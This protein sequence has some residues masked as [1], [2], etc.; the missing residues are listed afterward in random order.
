MLKGVLEAEVEVELLAIPARGAF[1]PL[2]RLA[3]TPTAAPIVREHGVR[4][5]ATDDAAR[6]VDLALMASNQSKRVGAFVPND[7][8]ELAM[9]AL[10]RAIASPLAADGAMAVVFEDDPVACPASCPRQAAMRLNIPCLEPANLSQLRDV[11]EFAMRLS[12]AGSSPVAIVVHHDLL[13]SSDTLRMRPNRVVSRFD[14]PLHHRRRRRAPRWGEAGGVMRIARRLELNAG[15]SIPSPGERVPVGFVTVGPADMALDHVIHVMKLIGRVP[16]LSLALV[17]P[18]DEVALERLLGR[19][20]HVV[21][22]EPRP[23]SVEAEV[24]A[25]AESLRCRGELTASVW[26]RELPPASDRETHCMEPGDALHPSTLARRV[27]HLLHQIRPTLDVASHLLRNVPA[28]NAGALPARGAGLGFAAAQQRVRAILAEAAPRLSDAA[29]LE[30]L[31][32]EP[33]SLLL[34]G[35]ERFGDSKRTVALEIWDGG[36]LRDEGLAAIRQAARDEQPRIVMILL[37]GDEPLVDVERL[38]AAAIPSDQAARCRVRT[39]RLGEPEELRDVIVES[40]IGEGFTAIVVDDA[41]SARF[42]PL[43]IERGLREVDRLGFSPVQT[44]S[45]PAEHVCDLRPLDSFASQLKSEQRELQLREKRVHVETTRPEDRTGGV[46]RIVPLL[47]HVEVVRSK[48]PMIAPRLLAATR[49]TAP[50]PVHAR[51]AQWRCHVAGWRGAAPGVATRV[52]ASAGRRMGYHVRVIHDPSPCSAGWRAFSQVLFTR[53]IDDDSALPLTATIPYGE[54]DLLVGVDPAES[55]R[56]LAGDRH[57]LV[58][59]PELTYAVVNT[60][61]LSGGP[62]GESRGVAEQLEAALEQLTRSERRVVLD[63][64]SMGRTV[65]HTDRVIDLMLLGAAFQHGL[66]PVAIEAME[67]ALR[68]VETQGIGRALE[69]FR[70]GRVLATERSLLDKPDERQPEPVRKVIR[71]MALTLRRSK[72]GGAQSARRFARLMERLLNAT[73]GLAETEAGREARRDAVSAVYQCFF[74]GGMP[75]AEQYVDRLIRVYDADRGDHG[76]ML[77]RLVVLPLAEA[78]LIR[79]HLHIAAMA[80]AIEHRRQIRERMNVKRTRGD[81]FER[82]YVTRIELQ[83]FG[84]RVTA[85]VRT[86]D[87]PARIMSRAS[88]WIPISF[89]GTA[90]QRALRQAM[91]DLVDKIVEAAEHDYDRYAEILRNLH[92]HAVNKTLTREIVASALEKPPAEH[93]GDP[94]AQPVGTV[95]EVAQADRARRS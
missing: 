12:K 15:K 62:A 2:L 14:A 58:A 23:G 91:F 27:V 19:C 59:Q 13:T 9:A 43:A 66:V 81:R 22:L 30:Q 80:T 3:A 24:L 77:T 55:L 71:R 45:W 26:G 69:V 61:R 16:V 42:S 35:K 51:A 82:R 20:E 18:I 94:A 64:A 5:T 87:W 34:H 33:T 8:L 49:L 50:P 88:R 37:V 41:P 65:L 39:A 29:A 78:M 47:E 75:Y 60:G 57:L 95:H 93:I 90:E 17:H 48:P 84:R 74:W 32:A 73:P 79:D 25:V 46:V 72:P 53:L 52:L 86:S 89:R 6:A 11:M 70:L 56:A 36:R 28:A 92:H 44:A 63:A 40:A 67:A 85:D 38:A 21:V 7:M 1:E 83:G 31:D 76:R 4:L 68:E 10:R 54:A